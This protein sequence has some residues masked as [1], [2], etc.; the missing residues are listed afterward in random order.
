MHGI[1][2]TAPPETKLS[3][4]RAIIICLVSSLVSII[5]FKHDN[6]FIG[7]L[8]LGIAA[9]TGLLAAVARKS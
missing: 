6:A 9:V 3:E 8:S 5:A 2:T 7:F 1:G 4:R